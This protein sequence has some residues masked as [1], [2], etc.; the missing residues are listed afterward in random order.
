MANAGATRFQ[1]VSRWV[2]LMAFAAVLALSA[3]GDDDAE[4]DTPPAAAAEPAPGSLPTPAPE[5]AGASLAAEPAAAAAPVPAEPMAVPA[6]APEP[7][8]AAPPVEPAAAPALALEPPPPAVPVEIAAPLPEPAPV[9]PEPAA[10][11]PDPAVAPAA[12]G[13]EPAVAAAPAPDPAVAAAAAAPAAVPEPAAVAAPATADP[14]ADPDLR[15]RVAAADPAAGAAEGAVC[16]ACHTI[17]EGAGPLIGPNLY[18]ILGAAVARSAGFNYSPGMVALGA[19]GATWTVER[20]DAFLANPDAAVPGTRMTL[21]G[22]EDPAERAN[23]IAW[24]RT[25]AAEP[26]EIAVEGAAT[27]GRRLPGLQPV[28]YAEEQ[29]SFGR[30]T[31]NRFCSRCHGPDF[32][33]RID[34]REWGSAPAL[35]GPI[36]INRWYDNTLWDVFVQMRDEVNPEFHLPSTPEERYVAALAYIL[37]QQ[38]FAAGPTPLT[39]D[40]ATLERMGFWQ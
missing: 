26:I 40:Q 13:P 35:I 24:L 29:I 3:C 18:G 28:A 17:E 14:P 34:E 19:A 21:S 8:P 25:L 6:V 37:Q 9:A 10:P 38:G 23:L 15:S 1:G 32:F 7:P 39:A 31:Y 11:A 36:F 30:D 22:I 33:G 4:D 16:A 12:A 5:V 2:P 20:L 27:I